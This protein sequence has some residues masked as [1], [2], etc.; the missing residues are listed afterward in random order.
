MEPVVFKSITNGTIAKSKSGEYGYSWD[1]IFIPDG[2]TR[3]LASFN[4]DVRF[5]YW[6]NTGYMELVD[7]LKDK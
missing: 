3:T 6:S 5:S 4:D 7:Y 1:Y 2:E